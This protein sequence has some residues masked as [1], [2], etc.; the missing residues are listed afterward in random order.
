MEKEF[1]NINEVSEYLG[2]KKTT[3]YFHAENGGIPHYRIGRLIRFKKQDVDQ[4]ME[5][6]KK[7]KINLSK[8]AIKILGKVPNRG[9]DVDS[10]VKKTIAE[11]KKN[12]YTLPQEKP[13]GIEGLRKEVKH[14]SI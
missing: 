5:G 13:G 10:I 1:L 7:E 6:N 12:G 4:W 14:G 11:T 2:I 3:L 9:G 8:M